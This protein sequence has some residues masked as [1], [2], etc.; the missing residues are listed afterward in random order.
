MGFPYCISWVVG[1]S[2]VL[3]EDGA[4][5]PAKDSFLLAHLD[6]L[7]RV[8]FSLERKS[9]KTHQREIPLESP[10]SDCF[11]PDW[12][13]SRPWAWCGGLDGW[14]HLWAVFTPLAASTPSTRASSLGVAASPG[15]RRP[16]CATGRAETRPTAHHPSS[17]RAEESRLSSWYGNRPSARSGMHPLTVWESGMDSTRRGKAPPLAILSSISHR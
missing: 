2:V 4:V 15:R 10:G 13:P 14:A 12:V 6:Q 5:L 1:S 11:L 8:T 3:W 16:G 7:R 17:D 9:P